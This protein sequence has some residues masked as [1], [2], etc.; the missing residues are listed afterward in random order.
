MPGN[1][2]V[3]AFAKDRLLRNECHIRISRKGNV[4]LT[5]RP[6][7]QVN[8][9]TRANCQVSTCWF[10]GVLHHF[11]WQNDRRNQTTFAVIF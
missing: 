5:T 3:D 11:A 1:I 4:A 6:I 7:Q 8:A 9:G 2:Y 10:S